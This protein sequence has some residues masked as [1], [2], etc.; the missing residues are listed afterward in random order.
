MGFLNTGTIA[1][2]EM[3][4][5]LRTARF[6]II[7][8]IGFVMAAFMTASMI[9]FNVFASGEIQTGGMLAVNTIGYYSLMFFGYVINQ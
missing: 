6:W 3:K 7:C 8:G 4:L 1:K 9:L 5:L 2:Y